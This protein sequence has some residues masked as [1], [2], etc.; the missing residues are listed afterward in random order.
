VNPVPNVAPSVSIISPV[1]LSADFQA[2]ANI[3]LTVSTSD[4]D[5]N[6]TKVGYYVSGEKI[7]ESIVAP[8]SFTWQNVPIGTYLI[9]ARAFDNEAAYTDS[10]AVQVTVYDPLLSY[11]LNG[12]QLNE[13]GIVPGQ[14]PGSNLALS[15]AWDMPSRI[16]KIY[17]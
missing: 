17:H 1:N 10:S 8:F 11:M 2:P 7:G 12:K 6:V 15:G 13:Y 3:P 16:G 4:S 14:A 5:G 9:S